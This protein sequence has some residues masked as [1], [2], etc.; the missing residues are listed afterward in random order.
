MR[1]II[2]RTLCEHQRSMMI[3]LV[4]DLTFLFLLGLS[5]AFAVEPGTPTF[6]ISVLNAVMLVSLLV[7]LVF[8]IRRCRQAE[9]V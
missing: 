2:F 4:L 6:V 7:V 5:F 9:R 8:F 3:L 1:N